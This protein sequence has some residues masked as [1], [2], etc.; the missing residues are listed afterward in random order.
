M[1]PFALVRL[2][3]V[4]TEERALLFKARHLYWTLTFAWMR[5][6]TVKRCIDTG[7]WSCTVRVPDSH[8]SNPH[9]RITDKRLMLCNLQGRGREKKKEQ[10][11][12]SLYACNSV[13]LKFIYCMFGKKNAWYNRNKSERDLF[14]SS[15]KGI[16]FCFC[17]VPFSYLCQTQNS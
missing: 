3:S 11:D 13:N 17:S 2:S 8:H 15:Y 1:K 9:Y 10:G 14:Y 7:D 6:L 4:A 12:Q 16:T 5:R